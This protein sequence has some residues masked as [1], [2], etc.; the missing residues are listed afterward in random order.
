MRS[1]VVESRPSRNLETQSSNTLPRPEFQ[2]LNPQHPTLLQPVTHHAPKY[3]LTLTP[4]EGWLA[5]L[6]LS[7][8]IY[9]VVFSIISANWVSNSFILLLA[10]CLAGH[11]ISIWL[12]SVIAFHISWLLL[13]ENLRTVISGG[14]ITSASPNSEVVF[15][16]YLTFLCFFLGYF[17][18]WLIY[19]AHLPWL[20][21]FVYC[22]IMLVNLNFI[23]QDRSYLVVIMLGALI[24]LIARIQLVNQLTQWTNEGLHTDRAW[25]RNISRRYVQIGSLFALSVL[26]IV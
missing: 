20:V 19:R 3:E 11:W 4:S 6:L 14:L 18:A 23:K 13:L 22:A 26:I 9:S 12:T 7:V 17:G 8:A 25:L 5:M 15:L 16:F 1:S 10:A 24:L 2:I 21:A